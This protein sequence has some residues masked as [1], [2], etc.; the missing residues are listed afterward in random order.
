MVFRAFLQSDDLGTFFLLKVR[1]AGTQLVP[2]K[3]GRTMM[4]SKEMLG[5]LAIDLK[6]KPIIC[7]KIC[8][9]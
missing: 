1:E 3:Q 9:T 7:K 8:S 6:Y 4:L 2:Q 5:S